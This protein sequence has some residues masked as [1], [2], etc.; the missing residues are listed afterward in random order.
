MSYVLL[1]NEFVTAA[2][3]E[4]L[5]TQ[6]IQTGKLVTGLIRSLGDRP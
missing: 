5:L 1:D 2:L 4:Q 3:Q 6:C